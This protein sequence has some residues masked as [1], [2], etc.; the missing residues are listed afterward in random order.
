M[1][2]RKPGPRPAVI[3]TCTLAPFDKP[4]GN[5]QRLAEGLALVDQ[6]AAEAAA[7]GWSLDI[8]LLPEHFAQSGSTAAEIAEPLSGPLAAAVAEKARRYNTHIALPIALD[9][10]GR[11]TNSVVMLDRA[12]EAA[13]TYRKCHPVLHLDGSLEHGICPGTDAPVWDLDVGRVGAQVCFDVFFDDTWQALDDAGAELV[14]FT[15]ATS[16][17]A[18]IKSHAWR[19][20]YYVAASTFRAPSVVVDPLGREVARTSGDKEVR[21]TRID[22]DYRVLPWNSLR[23]FGEVR[24]AHPAGLAPRGRPVPADVAGRLAAGRRTVEAREPGNP[25]RA[26]GAESGGLQGGGAIGGLMVAWHSARRDKPAVAHRSLSLREGGQ[27][28]GAAIDRAM[29]VARARASSA[30]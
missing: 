4:G 27:R 13:G 10:G 20:E 18:A 8:V 23:D 17:V 30:S 29:L 22:L 14:L 2:S 16:A 25:P 11:Y 26:P 7:A 12:G 24:P 28:L 19:H 15:S 1:T 9:E 6:M 3:G 5:P 21:L